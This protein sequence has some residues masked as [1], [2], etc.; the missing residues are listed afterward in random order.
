MS[1]LDII[2]ERFALPGENEELDKKIEHSLRLIREN[3]PKE[4]YY[5]AI[6][7]GK[8]SIVLLDLVRRAGVKYEA[9]YNV[10][11]IDP[12]EIF[13]FLKKHLG[14]VVF[15]KPPMSFQEAI[16]RKGPPTRR[17]R[18][19]CAVF[20]EP[21]GVGRV[22]LLGI[23][24]KES[25]RRKKIWREITPWKRGGGVAVLP[26]FE[27]TLLDVWLY[28]FRYNLPYC[29]V[30]DEGWDRL[31]CVGCPMAGKERERER[32]RQFKRWPHVERVWRQGLTRY[33]ERRMSSK[34]PGHCRKFSNPDEYF[35]WWIERK[36]K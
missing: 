4:G 30:Y 34:N 8:D 16:Y 26:L 33:W 24:A 19:C 27:W 22:K 31:G 13:V 32:E 36:G 28:I 9:R 3:E 23:R 7:G 12:P 18:W 20:K 5:T 10:I 15:E 14:E 21:G 25:T 2:D 29:S 35:D 6:S 11:P 17:F 1:I